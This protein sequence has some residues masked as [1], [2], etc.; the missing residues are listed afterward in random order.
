VR[1]VH[2]TRYRMNVDLDKAFGDAP[3]ELRE[4]FAASR[5]IAGMSRLVHPGRV[6]LDDDG[7]PRRVEVRLKQQRSRREAIEMT[8]T[9]ELFDI[10]EPVSIELPA[11]DDTLTVKDIA[12]FVGG[13]ISDIQAVQSQAPAVPT[14]DTT[15]APA[16]IETTVAP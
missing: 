11:E 5:E 8:L 10:G 7:L 1:G 15:V 13:Q 16:P 3:D 12:S 2:T 14:T 9:L 4:A 6:W